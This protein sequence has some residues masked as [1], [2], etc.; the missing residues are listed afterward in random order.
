MKNAN[1]GRVEALAA[2]LNGGTLRRVV[3]LLELHDSISEK[4]LSTRHL[5]DILTV[6]EAVCTVVRAE[7]ERRRLSSKEEWLSRMWREL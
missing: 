4:R 7:L 3:A 1:A 5:K 2:R 6:T